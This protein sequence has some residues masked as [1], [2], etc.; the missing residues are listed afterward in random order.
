MI[1]NIFN[2]EAFV[3]ISVKNSPVKDGAYFAGQIRF[4]IFIKMEVKYVFNLSMII[5]NE[6]NADIIS[7]IFGDP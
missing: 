7:V 2:S 3:D 5:Q 6:E 4:Q 1:Q